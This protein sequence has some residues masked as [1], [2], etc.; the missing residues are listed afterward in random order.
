MPREH[1][2]RHVASGHLRPPP[3]DRV[4]SAIP[5]NRLGTLRCGEYR[6]ALIVG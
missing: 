3:G 6:D 1:H 4:T 5:D 2:L